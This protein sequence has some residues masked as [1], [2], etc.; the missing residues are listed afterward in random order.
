MLVTP[1]LHPRKAFEKMENSFDYDVDL[2]LSYLFDSDHYYRRLAED[3]PQ[4]RIINEENDPLT[5]GFVL[6]PRDQSH[7]INPKKLIPVRPIGD[8]LEDPSKWRA[9]L[10]AHIETDIVQK[11]SLPEPSSENPIRLSFNEMIIFSWPV[12]Y[13][14]DDFRDNWGHIAVFPNHIR[15]IAAR[16]LYNLYTKIGVQTQSPSK[17]STGAF[18]GAHLRTAADAA[19]YSWT[20][21]EKQSRQ[22]RD[23]LEAYGLS[24]VYVATGNADDIDR[25]R[26]DVADM[27]IRINQTHTTGVQVFQ[28]WDLVDEKDAKETLGDLTWDQMAIIDMEIMLRASR[29]VGIAESSWGWMVALKRHAW[30][31]A[32]PYDYDA[33]PI[34]FEDELSILYGP[35]G[36]LPIIAP[37]TWL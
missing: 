8:V 20:S 18:L 5:T 27:K 35:K 1:V 6:P 23:Q 25:L 30:S 21:Y 36:A 10:D 28:K 29:F 24:V 4:L 17:P 2:P 26:N 31:D 11:H 33:H 19:S 12:D 16:A 32:D 15:R 14:P 37:C 34:T 9:A 7:E 3:C 13:D 22:I